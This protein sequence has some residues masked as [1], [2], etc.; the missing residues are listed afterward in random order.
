M[1]HYTIYEK[2]T[3]YLMCLAK[4]RILENFSDVNY[5]NT[6]APAYGLSAKMLSSLQRKCLIS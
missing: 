4:D 3:K 5:I 6:S 1:L 2:N